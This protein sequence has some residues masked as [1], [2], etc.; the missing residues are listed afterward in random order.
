MISCS[1]SGRLGFFSRGG[2]GG[3]SMMALRITASVLPG[4]GSSPTAML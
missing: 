3:F 1:F 4:K 2:T